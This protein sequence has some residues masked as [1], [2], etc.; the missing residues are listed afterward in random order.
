MFV[1]H[2]HISPSDYKALT[3]AERDAIVQEHNRAN[4]RRR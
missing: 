2:L 3:I 4:R 1:V